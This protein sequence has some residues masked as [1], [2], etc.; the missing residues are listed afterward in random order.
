MDIGS[1]IH[2][3]IEDQDIKQKMLAKRLDI[4]L[5]TFNGY[6]TGR[7]Q[8]PLDV[9]KKIAEELEITTDYMLGLTKEPYRP[10]FLTKAEQNTI[11]ALRTLTKEQRELIL[12]NISLMQE[13]NQRR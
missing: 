7:H 1:K 8:F 12:Q 9:V 3:I 13:Q 6:M 11:K 4:P 5:S 2:D 10:I